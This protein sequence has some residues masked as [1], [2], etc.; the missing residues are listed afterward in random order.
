MSRLRRSRIV[1]RLLSALL[2]AAAV[3]GACSSDEPRTSFSKTIGPDGGTLEITLADDN[4]LG[5]T[6]LVIPPNA[7][8]APTTI[9]IAHAAQIAQS[10]EIAAGPTV[11]LT[12]DGT[13]LAVPATLRLPQKVALQNEG[14]LYFAV[15]SGGAHSEIPTTGS[16][17]KG[18]RADIEHFSDY[19]LVY[20]TS[21]PACEAAVREHLEHPGEGDEKTNYF[22]WKNHVCRVCK[23][24]TC[25]D[26]HGAEVAHG[27]C[28]GAFPLVATCM[29][30]PWS[31]PNE[32]SPLLPGCIRE[33]AFDATLGDQ[34]QCCSSST[35]PAPD[36]KALDAKD[37]CEN[38][39]AAQGASFFDL[40]WECTSTVPTG[41]GCS[42]SGSAR[43]SG[44]D[45]TTCDWYVGGGIVARD[46]EDSAGQKMSFEMS[47]F[48]IGTQPRLP[49][50]LAQGQ[51]CPNKVPQIGTLIKL[52]DPALW[53]AEL[54]CVEGTTKQMVNT[55]FDLSACQTTLCTECQTPHKGY[56]KSALGGSIF[57]ELIV[58]S[59]A[60]TA[61]GDPFPSTKCTLT[62]SFAFGYCTG[63]LCK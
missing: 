54:T 29:K 18:S 58:E 37:T 3:V 30:G 2:A 63:G 47:G 48:P 25:G 22:C 39:C 60:E 41:P 4:E 50:S 43:F 20:V 5:G 62:G 11:R 34:A 8:A 49:N 27:G 19:E 31:P 46:L 12:P 23:D 55:N 36:T 14:T 26:D 44:R 24:D 16:D 13:K 56:F 57:C 59:V 33:A 38:S 40:K 10:G 15:V 45:S 21:N 53:P 35:P 9:T 42:A 52:E 7:L 32:P 51:T 6:Q 28:G 1:R 61:A 17:A